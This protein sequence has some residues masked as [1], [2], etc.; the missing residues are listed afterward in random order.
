MNIIEIVSD[1]LRYDAV[2]YHGVDPV[3]W[4]I[5]QRP[6]TPH[7]DRFAASAMVFDRAYTGSFPTIPMRTDMITGRYTFPFR[8]WTPLPDDE[9]TLAERLG[10]AGYV[11]MLICDTPHLIRD[12]HRFDRGF[13]AWHWTRGQEGDRAITDDVF[14]PEPCD[15]D[16]QRMPE[17]HMDCHAKWRA[18]GPTPCIGAPRPILLWRK[19][20]PTPAAGWSASSGPTPHTHERFYLHIDAFDPHE[21]WDPPQHYVDLYDPGYQGQVVDHP[22]Y[23]YVE[24]FLTPEELRHCRALYAGEVTLVDRWLGH[25]FE[26][27]ERLGLYENT[28]VLF[29][30]DHGHYIGDHGRV[31]KSGDG[32]D[33]PWPFYREVNQMVAIRSPMARVPGG[34]SG[35]RTAFLTQPV[36]ILPTILDLTGVALPEGLH[37]ISLK[38]LLYGQELAPAREVAVT[39]PGLTDDPAS[40]VCSTITDGRWALQ[41]RGPDYPAELHDLDQDPAQTRNVYAEE[42]GEAERLHLAYLELLHRA[43]AAPERVALRDRLPDGDLC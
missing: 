19:P 23:D 26:T 40:P 35:G 31:G 7:I 29:L 14:V 43:G 37:G 5:L 22:R 30:S 25:L 32:P 38:P 8:G 13:S 18:S 3:G 10:E 6:Q 11:S 33:G 39:S 15:P 41:Y 4:D 20:C 1:T 12:G 2:A 9:I 16:K 27:I 24:R 34:V 36:D 42:R 28:A 21:P 17:R